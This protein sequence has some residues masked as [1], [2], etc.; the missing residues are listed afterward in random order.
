MRIDGPTIGTISTIPKASVTKLRDDFA[1]DLERRVQRFLGPEGSE[2]RG[3]MSALVEP[4]M[5][6][7]KLRLDR[8]PE[9]AKRE[10]HKLQEAAEGIETMFVKDLLSRMRKTTLAEGKSAMTGM[11]EDW[12][13]DAISKSIAQSENSMGMA[14]TVFMSTGERLVQ[15]ALG[16]VSAA[17]Q[18]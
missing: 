18:P 4:L 13:D 6:D 5:E 16:R 8:L 9:D 7:G 3:R 12:M 14:K 15:E 11:A 10:L 17:A 1:K 2:Q